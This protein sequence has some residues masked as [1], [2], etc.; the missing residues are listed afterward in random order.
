MSWMT[1]ILFVSL[2]WIYSVCI[3][4]AEK[5]PQK[6]KKLKKCVKQQKTSLVIV[7]DFRGF[8]NGGGNQN[9]AKTADLSHPNEE[10]MGCIIFLRKN[11]TEQQNFKRVW[12]QMMAKNGSYLLLI[13][14]WHI[15]KKL[16]LHVL[17]GKHCNSTS[18]N[19]TDSACVFHHT[20]TDSACVFNHTLTD[21]CQIRC[22]D[23]GTICNGDSYSDET[24]SEMGVKKRYIINITATD[25]NCINCN[26]PVK[27]PEQKIKCNA[28]IITEGEKINATKASEV[29]NSMAN[30]VA[31]IKTSAEVTVGKELKGVIVTQRDPEEVD[32]VLFAY[33]SPH[34]SISIIDSEDALATFQ[35]S[36][37]VPKEAFEK[38]LNVSV[39]FAVIF[40]F[41]NLTAES[42]STILNDE[43]VA[44]AMATEIT[45]LTDKIRLNFH[46]VI[47]DGTPSCQSWNGEGS[48]PNWTGDGCETIIDGNNVTCACSHLTFFAILLAP[49][50]VTISS[51]DLRKLTIITQIGCGV[52]M[53]FLGIVL[54]MHFLLRRTKASIATRIL[55]HLVLALFLLNLTFLTNNYVAQLK[56]SVGCK[57]MAALMHYFMLATFTW[58]A[59]QAF[60]ICQQLY[61]GGKTVIRHYMIK[62]CITS[63]VLP[64]IV[65]IVLLS[66]GKYGEQAILTSDSTESISMCWITDTEVHSIVNIGYYA[67]VF[68]FTITTFIAIVSWLCCLRRVGAGTETSGKNIVIILGLCCMLGITWGFAFFA[69]GILRIPAYYIFTVLNSFQGFFLFI[70]YW[71]TSHS[72]EVMGGVSDTNSSSNTSTL[73]TRVDIFENPYSNL[74]EREK[75]LGNTG[76]E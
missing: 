21:S 43:V 45:N 20:L 73:K 60:H 32:Q 5:C 35:R 3:S 42:S 57:I 55:I 10:G 28:T 27:K 66:I 44:V 41:N 76:G 54:F 7:D 74:P 25:N 24:C 6:Y 53:F 51:S 14:Q 68:I 56:S 23:T 29:M 65:G 59:V 69:H 17:E 12:P 16:H 67:L 15:K 71:K 62:V 30:L 18:C 31:N 52:S 34:D 22:V 58:F 19:G 37:T 63:W 9:S 26:D 2:L 36:V 8:F 1:W 40:R 46:N 13:S 72:K 70:Y 47:Y 33:E 48:R 49:P 4:D 50:N 39:P 11:Q 38:S 61:M 75:K 64:S